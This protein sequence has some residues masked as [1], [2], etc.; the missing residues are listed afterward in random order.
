MSALSY[1]PASDGASIRRSFRAADPDRVGPV[2][3]GACGC[4]LEQRSEDPSRGWYHFDGAH[5]RDARGCSV[6]C[7]GLEHDAAGDALSPF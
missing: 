3:C 5:G 2:V 6:V 7:V 4:R 1:S